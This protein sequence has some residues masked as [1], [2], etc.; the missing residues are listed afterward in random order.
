MSDSDIHLPLWIIHPR[1]TDEK[2]PPMHEPC[3]EPGHT[4]AFS[5]TSRLTEFL[6]A[7]QAGNW[8][9]HLVS[10][11]HELVGVL[12]DIHS[13]GIPA[14]CIDTDDDGSGG[15]NLS[16]AEIIARIERKRRRSE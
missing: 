11:H 15:A 7:R 12:A 2:L 9:V 1:H 6:K 8:N 3:D 14:L 10:D 16:I 13:H 5:S 4:L